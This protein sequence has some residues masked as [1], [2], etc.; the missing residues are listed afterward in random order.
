MNW[1]FILIGILAAL[2]AVGM[3]FVLV[4]LAALGCMRLLKKSLRDNA[5]ETALDVIVSEE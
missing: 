3:C 2:V 5:L 4:S 1:V